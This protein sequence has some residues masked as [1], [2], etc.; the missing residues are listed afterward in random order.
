MTTTAEN[1]FQKSVDEINEETDSDWYT[2]L[3]IFSL[4]TLCIFFGFIV[5]WIYK[6]CRKLHEN[7]NTQIDKLIVEDPSRTEQI[8]NPEEM[9]NNSSNTELEKP[10][11]QSSDHLNEVKTKHVENEPENLSNLDMVYQNSNSSKSLAKPQTMP[12]CSHCSSVSQSIDL[13][14]CDSESRAATSSC[15]SCSALN[16]KNLKENFFLMRDEAKRHATQVS[17]QAEKPSYNRYCKP[18]LKRK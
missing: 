17:S 7:S 2:Y 15:S 3:I 12:Q 18:G 6:C 9:S 8:T 10:E 4:L 1:Y 13:N 5:Y 11:E 16:N 14:S